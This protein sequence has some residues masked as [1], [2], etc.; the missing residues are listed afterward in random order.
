[1]RN[2]ET[3]KLVHTVGDVEINVVVQ[4][5]LLITYV[6]VNNT[7]KAELQSTSRDINEFVQIHLSDSSFILDC[8]IQMH[9]ITFRRG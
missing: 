7:Y 1:M 2:A 8:P 3:K 9:K 4:L 6:A 5:G